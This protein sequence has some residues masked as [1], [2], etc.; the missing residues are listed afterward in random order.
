MSV[1]RARGYRTGVAGNVSVDEITPARLSLAVLGRAAAGC[2]A[3]PGGASP[4]APSVRPGP[5]PFEAMDAEAARAAELDDLLERISYELTT[6]RSAGVAEPEAL[7]AALRRLAKLT[8]DAEALAVTALAA[9][10]RRAG[11]G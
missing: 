5:L 8:N 2:T 1:V 3:P 4:C 7:R 10:R 6:A 11:Q 9:K